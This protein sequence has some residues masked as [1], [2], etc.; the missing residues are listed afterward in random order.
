MRSL[1]T[2]AL[3]SGYA[4]AHEKNLHAQVHTKEKKVGEKEAHFFFKRGEHVTLVKK[5]TQE[6][7]RKGLRRL[8]PMEV[9]APDDP[10][11]IIHADE[12]R[13]QGWCGGGLDILIENAMESPLDCWNACVE[14]LGADL[15]A[16][17]AWNGKT[18]GYDVGISFLAFC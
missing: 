11:A 7:P 1:I 12:Y 13:G 3:L 18:F 2:I 14:T 5:K 10:D 17:D 15:Q 9:E 8:A 16:I 4:L 6:N